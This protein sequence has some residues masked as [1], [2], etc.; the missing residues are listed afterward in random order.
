MH[1]WIQESEAVKMMEMRERLGRAENMT[2][3]QGVDSDELVSTLSLLP[4]S[5]I[6]KFDP[7][8]QLPL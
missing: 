4:Q 7:Q 8:P 3:G 6:V 2:D 1:R 5:S